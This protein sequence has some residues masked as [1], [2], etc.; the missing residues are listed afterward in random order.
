M[1]IKGKDLE[2]RV[3][4]R[5]KRRVGPLSAHHDEGPRNLLQARRINTERDVGY[6]KGYGEG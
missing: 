1:R 4:V 5:I 6:G 2:V 3:E